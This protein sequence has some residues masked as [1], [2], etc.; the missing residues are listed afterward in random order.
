MIED[1]AGGR[2]VDDLGQG[3]PYS[4]AGDAEAVAE[5]LNARLSRDAFDDTW[6]NS[7]DPEDHT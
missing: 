3:P 4:D 7:D 2:N 6:C 5:W 1:L